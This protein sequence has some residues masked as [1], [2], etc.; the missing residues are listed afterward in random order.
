MSASASLWQINTVRAP[1]PSGPAPHGFHLPSFILPLSLA[2]NHRRPYFPVWW[3]ILETVWL[4]KHFLPK[5][6]NFLVRTWEQGTWQQMLL[7]LKWES[8][9]TQMPSPYKD[10]RLKLL[11]GHPPSQLRGTGAEGG[12][13]RR[14]GCTAESA[15]RPLHYKLGGFNPL[16]E[17]MQTLIQKIQVQ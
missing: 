12:R 7:P 6:Y 10:V 5:T 11:P 16:L 13:A 4:W 15:L 3:H 8:G 1:V 14:P 9:P 2:D 17:T